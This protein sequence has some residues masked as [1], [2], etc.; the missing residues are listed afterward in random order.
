M[1]HLYSF[2]RFSRRI[3][4][5]YLF[6]LFSMWLF[7][8][9]S[10]AHSIAP[11]LIY[12]N[13]LLDEA[14]Y[15]GNRG[16]KLERSGKYNHAINDYLRAAAMVDDSIGMAERHGMPI[17]AVPWRAFF[18]SGFA[19]YDAALMH[20]YLRHECHAIHHELNLS[21][22]AFGDII[23][24]ESAVAALYGDSLPSVILTQ[25]YYLLGNIHAL[26]GDEYKA[27][28]AYHKAL[29]VNPGFLPARGRLAVLDLFCGRES[30]YITETEDTIALPAPQPGQSL[31][32]YNI[33]VNI[34][35]APKARANAINIYQ[36][37]H[38]QN[39]QIQR[40]GR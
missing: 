15:Y 25:T 2:P 13:R 40:R 17:N 35:H 28:Q 37:L 24:R 33:Q 12:M 8:T 16:R 23:H 6:V 21:K 5:R 26:L 4:L 36:N 27:R 20:I 19:H 39:T 38:S 11:R 1:F 9:P 29:V 30:G 31:G 34:I 10:T 18:I 7:L 3:F 14:V 32:D 22:R